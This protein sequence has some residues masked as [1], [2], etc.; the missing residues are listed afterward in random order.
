[1]K[2][3]D[4]RFG[5][6]LTLRLSLFRRQGCQFPL[7]KIQVF[8]VRQRLLGNLAFVGNMQVVELA[9]GMRPASDFGDAV[10]KA[11]FVTTI[12]VTDQ[13]TLL[14]RQEVSGCLPCPAGLEVV[15]HTLYR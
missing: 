6:L 12:V 11:G 10:G 9:P 3:I 15:N 1:M 7:N 2:V 13:F 14:I 5:A 4:D 8:D